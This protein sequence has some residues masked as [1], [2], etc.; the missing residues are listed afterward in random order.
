MRQP[1]VNLGL[2]IVAGAALGTLVFAI[3][4]DV[5]WVAIGPSLG[6]LVGSLMMASAQRRDRRG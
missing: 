3:T 6:V 4:G 5:M 1:P 2:A